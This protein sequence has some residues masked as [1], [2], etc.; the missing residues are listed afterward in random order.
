M[1][2]A[3][4]RE[5]QQEDDGTLSHLGILK[6]IT[7]KYLLLRTTRSDPR[8]PHLFSDCGSGFNFVCLF[9]LLLLSLAGS[10]PK[11][12]FLLSWRR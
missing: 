11:E 2:T 7:P 4:E 3:Y 5:L 9:L 12:E 1:S 6:Y 10:S 8:T